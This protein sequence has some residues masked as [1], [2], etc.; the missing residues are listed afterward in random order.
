[1][2]RCCR[3]TVRQVLPLLPLLASQRDVST[4]RLARENCTASPCELKGARARGSART[5]CPQSP[6]RCQFIRSTFMLS[7]R[8]TSPERHGRMSGAR[9][10]MNGSANDETTNKQRRP[11]SHD[12]PR[13][14]PRYHLAAGPPASLHFC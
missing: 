11:Y 7:C 10:P 13:N 5:N 6:P 2:N 8:V 12:Y 9:Q 3:H 1:M 4:R 14:D